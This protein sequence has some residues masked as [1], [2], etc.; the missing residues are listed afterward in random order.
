MFVF[1]FIATSCIC[2]THTYMFCYILLFNTDIRYLH[3]RCLQTF[4][5][6][7]FDR[8]RLGCKSNILDIPDVITSATT[9]IISH[10]T[11]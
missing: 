3:C 9:I 10:I 7:P 8:I 6:Q 2:L 5:E 4:K 1:G 11:S